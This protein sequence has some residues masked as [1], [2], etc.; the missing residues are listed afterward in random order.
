MKLKILL[1]VISLIVIFYINMRFYN[2]LAYYSPYKNRRPDYKDF[3]KPIIF[4]RSSKN[5]SS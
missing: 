2:F 4:E 1:Y 3:E 5:R